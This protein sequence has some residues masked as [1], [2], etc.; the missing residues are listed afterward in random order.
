MLI[1]YLRMTKIVLTYYV[2]TV[3]EEEGREKKRK[4]FRII[5]ASIGRWSGSWTTEGREPTVN[6]RP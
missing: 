1:A 5:D 2:D 6:L 3:N 4:L